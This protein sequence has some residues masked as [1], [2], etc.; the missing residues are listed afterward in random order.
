MVEKN[1]RNDVYFSSVGTGAHVTPERRNL[2]NKRNM[3]SPAIS[4]PRKDPI[5][6]QDINK[7]STQK[8]QSL[9]SQLAKSPP[10]FKLLIN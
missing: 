3:K 7:L 1:I 2:L 6:D 9:P 10:V 8:G 4:P 5:S